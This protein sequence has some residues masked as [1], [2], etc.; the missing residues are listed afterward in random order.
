M[1][2]KILREREAKCVQERPPGCTAGCPVHVDVRGLID[3]VRKGDYAGGFALFHSA[4][5]FPGILSRFCDQPCRQACKRNEIDEPISI[6]A[7]ERICVESNDK[8]RA[9]FST[10]P[11]KHKKVA[12]VGAGLS[13]LTAVLELARRGYTVVVFEATGNLGG[14]VWDIPEQQLPRQVIENDLAIFGKLPVEINYHT[15]IGSRGG[16]I[17]SF[18]SLCEE[19]D[20][21]YLGIGSKEAAALDLNLK[22]DGD[23]KIVIDP[24]TLATSN[25]KIFAGG[26]LRLGCDGRSLI[27]S[28]SD[29][30]IA[31]NSID[32]LLQNASLTANREKEG[33]YKTALYTSIEGLKPESAVAGSVANGGYT[34]EEASREANRCLLCECRECVKACEYLAHY[35]AYPKRYVR[36]VYN[37]LSIVMGIHRANKMINTCNLCGLCEQVC[38]G[39]LNM[40]EIYQEA[41]RMMVERG[42]MPPSTHE[43]ALRDMR[44]SNGDDFALSK[45]QPGFSSSSYVFYPG[46]QHAAS[47]PESIR[48]IYDFLC[49]KIDGGVGLM[50]GC[51]G[52]PANWA[53]QESLFQ[54]TLQKL[55]QNWRDLGRPKVITACPT[56]FSMFSR[57]LPDMPVEMLWTLLDKIGLPASEGVTTAK[58]QKLAVHDSCTTRHEAI[59]QQSVRNILAKLGYEVEELPLSRKNTVCCGYG[60]LMIYGDRNVANKVIDRR[61]KESET[62]YLAYCTMCRDNFANQ[63]KR[64][65]YLLDLLFGQDDK[66]AERGSPGY[67]ERQENRAR[68]KRT[69]LREVWGETVD[70]PTAPVKVIIPDNVIRIM[71]ERMILVDDIM[72]VIAHAETT[73]D[74]LQDTASGH[75]LA[76]Y[77]PVNVTYWVEYS[78]Q[79]DGFL[80]HNT[81]SHRIEILR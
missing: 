65:Y 76:Y 52:A 8:P 62:D 1:D 74:K 20:A 49:E 41:R 43:F 72:K 27:A 23:G 68:L 64:A 78:P 60:G 11:A 14:S 42:K 53:G 22:R 26:S 6:N 28:I 81:Y 59:L 16:S 12:V 15:V 70:E 18:D 29:G 3:A 63:G 67:S 24:L 73:G 36:E 21:V 45:H 40:G 7:L 57:N 75:Y 69:L 47:S 48:K 55:E 51:C 46:C 77:R 19:Y 35:G 5:P 80:V 37:N 17:M 56:C 79:D 32:R 4:V 44:F 61:V 30:K 10:L 54:E 39:G 13:G 2:Q 9:P 38:P 33:P 58:P 25:P 71:E 50:L 66:M 31:A 34:K